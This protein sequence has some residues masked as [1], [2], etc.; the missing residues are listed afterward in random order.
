MSTTTVETRLLA[1]V[2]FPTQ[3]LARDAALVAGTTVALALAA[4]L[5]LPLPFTPVPVTGQ[6]LVALLAGAALGSRRGALAMLGYLTAGALG[7]PVFAGGA[8]G[9]G[10]AFWQLA[11]GGYLL[12]LLFATA[13]VGWLA[14]R[15]W[16]RG[17]RLFAA[18]TLG[19]LAVYALGLPWLAAFLAAGGADGLLSRTLALGFLPFLPGDTV[20]IVLAALLL[21]AARTLLGKSKV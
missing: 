7:A 1:D 16:Q 17:G 3:S 9:A 18:L 11:T 13:L 19:N 6:T 15:G 8:G 20:K 2:L 14:E 4:Q 21:P 10:G 5:K 12:G